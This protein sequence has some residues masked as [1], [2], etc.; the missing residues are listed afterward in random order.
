MTFPA[1]SADQIFPDDAHRLLHNTRAETRS[2]KRAAYRLRNP[3]TPIIMLIR[4]LIAGITH[5]ET[6]N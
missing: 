2:V 5:A 1:H 6:W 3:D 4:G